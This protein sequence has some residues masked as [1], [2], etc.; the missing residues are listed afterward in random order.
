MYCCGRRPELQ[1]LT[2]KVLSFV[3]RAGRCDFGL[4]A[5]KESSQEAIRDLGAVR[6]TP[7]YMAPEVMR[8]RDFNEKADVY[9]FGIVLW[10]RTHRTHCTH[11]TR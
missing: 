4:S 2:L 11:R 6:G 9:S 1:R 3:R 10:Y 8:K 7:L 5:I